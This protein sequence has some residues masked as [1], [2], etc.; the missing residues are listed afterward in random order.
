[1]I[2]YSKRQA[3]KWFQ[4]EITSNHIRNEVMKELKM[5]EMRRTPWASEDIAFASLE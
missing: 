2:E 4:Y 3:P 1:M 5:K